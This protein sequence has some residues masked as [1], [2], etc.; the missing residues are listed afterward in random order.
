MTSRARLGTGFGTQRIQA[1]ARS[2]TRLLSSPPQGQPCYILLNTALFRLEERFPCISS[3]PVH[4]R[5]LPQRRKEACEQLQP[6]RGPCINPSVPREATLVELIY[7]TTMQT[8][9][10]STAAVR[11]LFSFPSP[12]PHAT[13]LSF[14]GTGSGGAVVAQYRARHTTIKGADITT[15][16]HPGAIDIWIQRVIL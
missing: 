1:W 2:C 9:R 15:S 7:S 3:V 13:P 6:Q 12:G 14:V 10:E 8:G 4:E 16:L 5:W 11:I